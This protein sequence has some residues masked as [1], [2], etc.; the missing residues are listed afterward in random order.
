[1]EAVCSVCLKSKSV[2]DFYRT[3]CTFLRCKGCCKMTRFC[4]GC[5]TPKL[6]TYFKGKSKTCFDCRNGVFKQQQGGAVSSPIEK[7]VGDQLIL[8]SQWLS[9]YNITQNGIHL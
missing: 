2:V 7:Y 8:H 3:D 5:K 9:T 1:M 6:N 4:D